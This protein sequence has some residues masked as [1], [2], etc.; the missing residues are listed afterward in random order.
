MG[1]IWGPH[2]SVG[3]EVVNFQVVS[4]QNA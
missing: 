1:L 3:R 2:G 4:A